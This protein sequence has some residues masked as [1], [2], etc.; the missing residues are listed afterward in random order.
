MV[1]TAD[2]DAMICLARDREVH[3][4]ITQY[5]D[6]NL[7][8]VQK[9]CEKLGLPFV[10]TA[11]Q[12]ELIGNKKHAKD[13]CIKHGIPVPREFYITT[14]FRD[15]DLDNVIYP[16]LTKP[17]DNSGQR[18]ISICR[19]K[20]QLIEGYKK[21]LRFS[22]SGQVIVE[23]Y[24]QGEYVVINFTLQDGYLSLSSMADKPVIDER[25]SN[26]LVRLPKGY[27]LPSK[28]VDL[29]YD[30][31]YPRF[32]NLSKTLNLENGSWGVEAVVKDRTFFIFEMQF[33]LG[34]MRHH[35]FVL[36]ETGIDIMKMHIRYA[37]TGKFSGWNLRKLDNPRFKKTHCL[38]NLLLKPGTIT[39]IHGVEK[40]SSM[41]GVISFLPMRSAGECIELTGTVFQI[42]GKVSLVANGKEELIESIE[43]IHRELQVLDENGNQM[44]LGSITLDEITV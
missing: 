37:L 10:A 8:N 3:G 22:P 13:L 41:P 21:A 40:I 12:L 19:N 9:I 28:Y 20:D 1:S 15:C 26:G 14:E 43:Q 24:L 17:V 32:V 2:I 4:V 16:V 30:T 38:L 31:L 18:G 29:F 44:L 36:Q 34:G 23:E 6:S 39:S 25:Y 7:P 35:Q 27:V 5:I 33:R 11:E 42:F